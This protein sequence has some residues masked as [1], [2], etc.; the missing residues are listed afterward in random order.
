MR[1]E[2]WLPKTGID[3]FGHMRSHLGHPDNGLGP[4]PVGLAAI[5][6]GQ[7]AYIVAELWEQFGEPPH[8]RRVYV[9]M[10]VADL[11]DCEFVECGRQPR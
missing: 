5:V 6:A 2:S 3:R 4:R 8:R 11:Q 1:S 10:Q 7:H 9:D